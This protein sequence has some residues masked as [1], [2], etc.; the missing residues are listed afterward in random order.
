MP[1]IRDPLIYWCLGMYGSA[2]TWAFNLAQKIAAAEMPDRPIT[3]CFVND[4]LPTVEE[5]RATLVLK[6]HATPLAD[7][8]ADAAAGIIIT[9]RDPRDAVAS[10]VLHTKTPFDHAVDITAAA[11]ATCVR[12]QSHKRAVVLRFEDRFFDDIGTLDRLA[13]L[14]DGNLTEPDRKRIFAETR[15]DRI[16]TFIAQMHQAPTFR[17]GFDPVTGQNYNYDTVTG[18]H[19]HHAGRKAE[20]GMW[21]R[22]LSPLQ[23]RTIEQRLGPLMQSLS[24]RSET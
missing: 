8:M 10:H 12:F 7:Q 13:G 16:E 20:I 2:S 22:E 11:A 21:R 18:W 3:A 24:Y 19:K 17:S 9:V 5:P 1:E 4:V 23:V 14:F 15:R 6:T